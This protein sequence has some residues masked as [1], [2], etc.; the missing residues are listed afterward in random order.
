MTAVQIARI[1]RTKFWFADPI[2]FKAQIVSELQAFSR[3]CD[4]L[5]NRGAVRMNGTS[6][7]LW[8]KQWPE[9]FTGFPHIQFYDYTKHVKRCLGGYVLPSNYHLTFSRSEKNQADCLRVLEAGRHN[10]AVVFDGK[11][12]P[13]SWEGFPTYS[14]DED[15]LRFLDPPGGHVGAL[16][17]K[18]KG[19]RDDTGFV[20]PL[21]EV[22]LPY[23]LMVCVWGEAPSSEGAS[24]F[25]LPKWPKAHNLPIWQNKTF[26]IRLDRDKISGKISAYKQIPSHSIRD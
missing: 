19:K 13:S 4:K 2:G 16:Y 10:V 7:I 1:A 24:L 6:D 26:R 11:N 22:K 25:R 23:W 14:A 20:I 8:E 21:S 5:G 12:F 9:L 17:A 3:R 15:D 18:G